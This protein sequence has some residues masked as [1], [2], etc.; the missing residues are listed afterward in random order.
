MTPDADVSKSRLRFSKMPAD[1]ADLPREE[2]ERDPEQNRR[3]GIAAPEGGLGHMRV[4]LLELAAMA[5]RRA[6]RRDGCGS[7]ARRGGNVSVR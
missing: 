6:Y 4:R 1:M 5:C 2:M 3:S 7:A